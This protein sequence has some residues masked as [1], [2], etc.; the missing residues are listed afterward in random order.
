MGKTN[1]VAVLQ[2]EAGSGKTTLLGEHAIEFAERGAWCLLHDPD[3]QFVETIHAVPLT[4]R[5]FRELVEDAHGDDELTVPRLVSITDVEEEPL[6]R[7]ALDLCGSQGDL[8]FVGYDE[9]VLIDGASAHYVSPVFKNILAR[10]RHWGIAIETLC[11]D[12]GL[13]HALWQRLATVAYVFQCVDVDR[14]KT[15]AKKF[16]RDWR[17]L[18]PQLKGL[19]PYEYAVLRK[20]HST[21][22]GKV[23]D[24]PRTVP[25]AS[26][27]PD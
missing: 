11:Q 3:R 10:R 21:T 13:L 17:E 4:V 7:L 22:H 26:K 5:D 25:D 8:V 24:R 1:H 2:G 18:A 27:T 6:T 16:G 9:A 20:G 15:I 19:G 14:S 23:P 12:F